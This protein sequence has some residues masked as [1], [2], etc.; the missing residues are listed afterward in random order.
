MPRRVGT[1]GQGFY[2]VFGVD[3]FFRCAWP[4][5]LFSLLWNVRLGDT[6][7]PRKSNVTWGA[8]VREQDNVWHMADRRYM[9]LTECWH[10]NLVFSVL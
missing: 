4:A 7:V 3:A 9:V 2:A 8:S 1:T 6:A 5:G 10:Y